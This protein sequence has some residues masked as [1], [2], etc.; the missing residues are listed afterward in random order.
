MKKTLKLM[1]VSTLVPALIAGCSSGSGN[2]SGSKN[3]GE[4]GSVRKVKLS[5]M[6]PL[7]GRFKDQ[8]DG[9]LK[10]F[11]AKE[12]AEKNIEVSY[13]LELPSDENLLPTRLASGDAPD[14]YSFNFATKGADF[15]KGGYAADLSN[16]PF[17]AKLTDSMREASKIDGKIYGVPM[18]SFSWSYL[19][20]KDIFEANNVTPPQTL[21]ELKALAEKL[22]GNNVTPFVL[23]YKDSFV[24]GWPF[25]LSMQ[26]IVNTK[27]PT[28]WDDMTT[29]KAS[30][31]DLKDN[32]LF[33]VVDVINA[34]GNS[35][36][37]EL[38]AEDGIADFANG[39]A[40]MFVTGPWYSDSILKVNP[41]F[42]LGLGALPIN[43]DPQSTKVVIAITTTLTAYPDGPNKDVAL[44]F[45]N[46]ILDDQDSSAFFESLKFNKVAT[47]QTIKSFPWD[48][49]A[50]NI[51]DAGQGFLGLTLPVAADQ[52]KDKLAQAYY[53]KSISQDQYVDSVNKTWKKSVGAG[54]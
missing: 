21:S 4:Q 46:Y 32:G 41:N 6:L 36:A 16:E 29:D 26:S 47:N 12:L 28:W 19:Y 53:A 30:F 22:K 35:N 9:Y 24:A 3:D 48:E 34:N 51:V 40:A 13:N 25:F 37:L 17:V 10:Q 54:K 31:K 7:A 38:S 42:N 49:D 39:K 15:V 27:L 44:D 23:A 50:Q 43:D 11:A 5:I 8:F 1:A 14:I 45:L 18:E 2:S 20:N 33:D 52:D